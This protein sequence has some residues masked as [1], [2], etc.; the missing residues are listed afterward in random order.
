MSEAGTAEHYAETF[1][2]RKRISMKDRSCFLREGRNF[3]SL[4]F[5]AAM[6]SLDFNTDLRK[7]EGS[8]GQQWTTE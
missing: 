1:H 7:Q 8:R 6:R 2:R 3:L 4:F 5:A